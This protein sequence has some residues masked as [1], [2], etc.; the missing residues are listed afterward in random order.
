MQKFY[1]RSS[2]SDNHTIDLLKL[3]SLNEK[4]VREIDGS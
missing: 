4:G 2:A 1:G 3:Q